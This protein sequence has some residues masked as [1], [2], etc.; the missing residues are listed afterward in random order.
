MNLRSV[1]KRIQVLTAMEKKLLQYRSE[2]HEA[3]Y[4]DFKKPF[5]ETD[6][7]ELYPVLGEIEVRGKTVG[8]LIDFLTKREVFGS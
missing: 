8:D 3:L 2:F 4:K 7:T 5:A 6:L 1:R